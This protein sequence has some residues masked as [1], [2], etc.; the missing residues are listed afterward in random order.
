MLKQMKL[1]ASQSAF[2]E[3]VGRWWEATTGSRTAGRILGWL[4]I[5]EPAH[6]SSADLM[7]ALHTSAGSISTQIRVLETIGLVE[8][9][10]FPGDRAT[11]FQ[12]LP[13]AWIELM[14]NEQQRI[15]GLAAMARDAL[16]VAPAERPDRV[17][18]LV[19][20]TEFFVAE[21]PALMERLAQHL[22]KE[23]TV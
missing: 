23:A 21:W 12:L 22:E 20:I 13:H 14:E 5:C 6:Q 7:E 18:D 8:R 3:R 4:M 17:T 9:V 2:V 15:V 16:D 10:T 19:R 1:A 11:Y